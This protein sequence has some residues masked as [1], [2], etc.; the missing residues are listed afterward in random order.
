MKEK[1]LTDTNKSVVIAGVR[2]VG[3]GGRGYRGIN[4]NEK[5]TIV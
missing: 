4:G 5:N 2:S 1:G 3:G